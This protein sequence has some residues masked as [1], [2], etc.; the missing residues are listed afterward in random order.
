V[1]LADADARM[2]TLEV[3]PE[4]E[5][6]LMARD[7]VWR[8]EV[9]KALPTNE[10]ELTGASRADLAVR[11]SADS[12]ISVNGTAVANVVVDGPNNP[13]PDVGPYDNGATGG[14]WSAVR[15][16]YLDDLRGVT[17]GNSESINMGAR[18]INGD[19]FDAAVPTFTFSASTG[20]VQELTIK[21][22]TNHP[23]HQH[24][25]HMQPQ[26]AC[27]DFE[28][29]EWYDTIASNCQVRFD[30]DPAT[31]SVYDGRTIMHCHILA[32]EDQGAM[33]WFDVVGGSPP[34]VH[35]NYPNGEKDLYQ[36]AGG[37][38]VCEPE[39]PTEL[40]CDDD[41][42]NDCDGAI[43]SA[44]PDCAAECSVFERAKDCNAEPTC[45]WSGKNKVCEP[46]A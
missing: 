34:P 30:L 20:A 33:G 11:C 24:V 22:A 44:D 6:V 40:I 46:A 13:N 18:T 8:T 38:P 27:G 5:A 19:K 17:P 35:P 36:C 9:P 1:L 39:G 15:P 32:H 10:I 16:S 7:G 28:A 4:C 25:Y 12:T 23:Y 3:G 45:S 43:D 37:P 31:S 29:G 14:I 26:A 41:V 21:G 42:D 2:K